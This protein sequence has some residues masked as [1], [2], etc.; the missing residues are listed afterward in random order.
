MEIG[1]D[2]VVGYRPSK[3]VMIDHDLEFGEQLLQAAGERGFYVDCYKSMLEVGYVGR[4]KQYDVAIVNYE[5]GDV[6]GLEVAEYCE[7]LLGNLPLILVCDEEAVRLQIEASRPQSV[8]RCLSKSS[9]ISAI[10]GAAEDAVQMAVSQ[11]VGY[12]YN[13]AETTGLH[14]S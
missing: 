6:T 1:K 9:G 13:E 4:F 14:S 10:L 7:K 2:P 3:F 11:R 8:F 12:L 5:L